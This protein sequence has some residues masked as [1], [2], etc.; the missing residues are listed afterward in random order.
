MYKKYTDV[1]DKGAKPTEK[2]GKVKRDVPF[3]DK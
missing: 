2:S 3:E 1:S